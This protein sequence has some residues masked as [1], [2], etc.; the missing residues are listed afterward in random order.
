MEIKNFSQPISQIIGLLD[1]DHES[2]SLLSIRSSI[3]DCLP[4]D[5]QHIW[6][7]TVVGKYIDPAGILR[8]PRIQQLAT[9]DRVRYVW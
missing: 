7:C 2:V 4:C 3:W 5:P 1:V 9:A 6:S 8:M